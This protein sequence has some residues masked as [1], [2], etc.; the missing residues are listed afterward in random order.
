MDYVNIDYSFMKNKSWEDDQ[1][2]DVKPDCQVKTVQA[3]SK[4]AQCTDYHGDLISI[5][6]A[7][8]LGYICFP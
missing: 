5:K 2:P 3:I 1:D 8:V 6:F 7:R 4:T